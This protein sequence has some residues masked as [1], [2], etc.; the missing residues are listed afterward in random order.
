MPQRLKLAYFSPLNPVQSGISDYSEELLP[1]LARYADL[2]LY[3][4]NYAPANQALAHQFKVYPAAKFA[5]QAGRY[6]NY[7]FHMGNSA[8]HAYIY[9][10]LLDTAASGKGI[11]VLHDF[12][13]HHFMI[14]QYLNHGQAA[15]YIRQMGRRYGP[16]GAATAREVI[17]GKFAESLFK[18]PFNETA[19]EAAPA[20]LV[21]SRYARSQI[22]EKYPGKPV[23]VA[24]MGVPLPPLVSRE[25]ARAR[26]G[27]PQAEFILVSLGHLNP[28]KRLDSALWAYRAFRR[29][30][31][32]SRFVLVGS[33]SPNYDVKSMISALGLTNSVYLTGYASMAQLQDYTAAADCCINLRYPTA[34]ETSASLLRIMGAG[35]P[36]MVSRTGAFEELPDDSCIK[37]DVDDAEEELLL[38]YLR[39]LAR[40][41]AL[42]AELGRNARRYVERAARLEDAAYDYYRFICRRLGR[43]LEIEPVK[44]LPVTDISLTLP[45]P[46]EPALSAASPPNETGET[47]DKLPAGWA[48]LA[49]AAAEIGLDETDPVLEEVTRAARFAGL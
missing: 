26:L 48:D 8:A 13:L 16:E 12:V 4:D 47:V 7:L 30:Y 44:T 19:I 45:T 37:V 38:E 15:E 3:L 10:A 32:H 22:I 21:H 29:E 40:R 27:L 49:Q 43:P 9:R 6:D 28:Y 41:P 35:R 23:G 33:P 1:A 14:G 18:Y 11:L 39:L 25:T 24:R 34:G 42:C 36:V 46:P 31:P 20:V 2:D 5:R 17:K